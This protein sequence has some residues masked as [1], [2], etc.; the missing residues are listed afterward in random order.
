MLLHSG[1]A[2]LKPGGT[3]VYSTCSL[4]EHENE[5]VIEKI[6]DDVTIEHTMRYTPA[7][8]EPII[9]EGFFLARLRR[10]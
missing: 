8:T 10:V 1:L 5:A 9:E 2:A 7:R 6:P 4:L 3:L